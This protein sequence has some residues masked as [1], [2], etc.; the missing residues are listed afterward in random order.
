MTSLGRFLDNLTDPSPKELLRQ[1][2]ER[3]FAHRPLKAD[4]VTP[5][6]K[7]LRGTSLKKWRRAA[8]RRWASYS[9]EKQQAII[10]YRGE[11]MQLHAYASDALA[12][13]N[14]RPDVAPKAA[15]ATAQ[16]MQGDYA[17]KW[18]QQNWKA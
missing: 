4:T 11:I 15:Q 8:G 16:A 14:Q 10:N 18:P 12:Y 17:Y 13:S 7:R 3:P 2:D 6:G 5:D 9:P 1:P